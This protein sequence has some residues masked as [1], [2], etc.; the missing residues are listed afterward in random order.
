MAG[1]GGDLIITVTT[2]ITRVTTIGVII[3]TAITIIID[4]NGS[5]AYSA[6]P[7]DAQVQLM[8]MC[9]ALTNSQVSF[10]S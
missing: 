5:E 1:A 4:N 9:L 10:L 8:T 2:R 6:A 3:A 7:V